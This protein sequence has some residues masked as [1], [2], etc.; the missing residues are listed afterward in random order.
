MKQEKKQRGLHYAALSSFLHT[1]HPA[2]S[3]L[4]TLHPRRE[5]AK[6][7]AF[8]GPLS[9]FVYSNAPPWHQGRAIFVGSQKQAFLLGSVS[10]YDFSPARGIIFSLKRNKISLQW[11]KIARACSGLPFLCEKKVGR[12]RCF[13]II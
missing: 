2:K 5:Q 8:R 10:F 3:L 13:Y 4:I 11:V 9:F 7:A 6:R 1:P 12:I